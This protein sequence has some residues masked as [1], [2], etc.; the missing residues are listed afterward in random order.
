M[1][2]P[3]KVVLSGALLAVAVLATACGT[4]TID[5]PKSQPALYE[6]ATLFNQRCSG[7][8]TLSFAATHGS[9]A[10][11]RT[12]Q[13]NTGPNF[14][15]RCERP[16]ARVLYAIENGG[17]SGQIMPQNIVVGQQARDVAQFVATY[18]G[19]KAPKIPGV[20]PC[21][22][23]PIGTIEEALAPVTPATPT[24]SPSPN[25][26][27]GQTTTSA[28]IHSTKSRHTH[29][30]TLTIS[31]RAVPGL[32]TILVN[33]LGHTLYVFAPDNRS[34]V[35]C[36][37][38]CTAVWPPEYLPTGGSA[39]GT[40][41]VKTS[42]LGSLPAQNGGKVVTYAGWPLYTYVADTTAGS[43]AGQAVNLNGGY[44]YV[45]TTSGTVVKKKP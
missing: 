33:N 19:R 30:K 34:R 24:P 41:G 23:V 26:V 17:F 9:G 15:I 29:G 1:S 13:I 5:V 28:P 32:G 18:S 43:A 2:R 20:V 7:C 12:N 39:V 44:W 40:G 8:H 38:A 21:E 27:T 31:S 36:T 37:G 6:G 16:V 42:L 11:V 22:Q 35:T 45:I 10:N 3:A 4:E 14:D 25:T